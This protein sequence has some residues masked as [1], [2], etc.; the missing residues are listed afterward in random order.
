MNSASLRCLRVMDTL[1]LPHVL[2]LLHPPGL[3]SV[4]RL[5]STSTPTEE[6]VFVC[7]CVCVTLHSTA[8]KMVVAHHAASSFREIWSGGAG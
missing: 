8:K 2:E 1:I 7:V 4:I 3:P 5:P 6:Q